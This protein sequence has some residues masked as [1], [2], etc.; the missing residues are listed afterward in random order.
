MLETLLEELWELDAAPLD[1]A[2]LGSPEKL[3][4]LRHSLSEGVQKSGKLY[5]F[6]L[7]FKRG[8]VIAYRKTIE[9][10]LKTSHPE[11]KLCDF[12]H[13]GDGA[14]HSSLVLDR[15]DPRAK[16]IN[17]EAEVRKWM[18]DI[19]VKEFGGSYSAEHGL[20]KKNMSA[21]HDYTPEEVKTITR[22]I[23]TSIAPGKTG[24]FSI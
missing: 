20:G 24:T 9:E 1:N 16:D 12:G 18:N 2:L 10:R 6:D 19:V 7:S 13:I 5:G 3:W 17:Y 15:D 22:I 4:H 11:L 21:Y 14:V 23:K 8:D